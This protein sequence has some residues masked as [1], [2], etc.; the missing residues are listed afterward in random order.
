MDK[1]NFIVVGIEYRQ[2]KQGKPYRMLHLSQAFS[3]AKYG[4]GSR[5]SVEYVSL[6]NCPEELRVGNVVALSYGRSFDGRAYVNGVRII[7]ADVPTIDVK[8]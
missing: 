2:S 8:K 7:S 3:D 4:V 6:Q 1:D 5:T